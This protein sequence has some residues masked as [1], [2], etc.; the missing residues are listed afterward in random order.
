MHDQA[1]VLAIWSGVLHAFG[2]GFFD[3]QVNIGTVRWATSW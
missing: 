2:H 1:H 3:S